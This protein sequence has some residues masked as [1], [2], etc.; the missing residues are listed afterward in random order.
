MSDSLLKGGYKKEE[1]SYAT[2]WYLSDSFSLGHM[3]EAF[4]TLL[5]AAFKEN[6]PRALSRAVVPPVVK[7]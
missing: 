3:E 7:G 4:R 5:S 1:P 2:I 6:I